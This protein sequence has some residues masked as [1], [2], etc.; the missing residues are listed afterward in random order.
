MLHGHPSF[1]QGWL[2]YP[3]HSTIA[4]EDQQQAFLVPP[5]GVRKIV[6]ATNIA[7]TGIT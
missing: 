6:I 4:S 5:P 7:E 1:S 3:L 2:V